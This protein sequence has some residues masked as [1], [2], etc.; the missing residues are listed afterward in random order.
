MVAEAERAAAICAQLERILARPEFEGAERLSNF[1]RFIVTESLAGRGDQ[2]KEYVIGTEVYRKPASYEP[3]TDATVRVEASKLRARLVAYYETEG[4]NAPILIE[5]PKG[6]Y[7]PVFTVRQPEAAGVTPASALGISWKYA[8]IALV[9]LALTAGALFVW[10]KSPTSPQPSAPVPVTAYPGSERHPS[11]S[12]DGSQVAFDWSGPD[13]NRDIYV[14]LVSGGTPLRLTSDPA[15]DE[16]PSWSPDGQ[17]IA[18]VRQGQGAFVVSALGGSERKGIPADEIASSYGVM[19]WTPDSHSLVIVTRESP[20]APSRLRAVSLENGTRTELTS[21]PPGTRGDDA[22]AL[23][24][25]GSNIAFIRWGD[26]TTADVYVVPVTGGEPKRI[27]RHQAIMWGVTWTTDGKSVVFASH[28]GGTVTLWRASVEHAPDEHTERIPGIQ[29]VA[30]FPA[31]SR[32]KGPGGSRLI[33][34]QV[35]ED[36]NIWAMALPDPKDRSA[37]AGKPRQVIAST[38][39]DVTPQFSPDGSR[40]SFASN[41]TGHWEI[42]TCAADGSGLRQLTSIRGPHIG[43]ARWSPNGNLLA[44]NFNSLP[45]RYIWTIHSDGSARRQ[46]MSG[47]FVDARAA[48]SN[49]GR[50][51]FFRSNRSGMEQI[52]RVAAEGGDPAQI[53]RNGGFEPLAAPDGL[54]IYYTQV[55]EPGLW[56]V[57]I[58]GGP[59]V[60][61]LDRVRHGYWTVRRHGVYFFDLDDMPAGGPFPV[62]FWDPAGNK[63]VR[64]A[65]A[66]GPLVRY[67]PS[68]DVSPD[69]R[70]LMWAKND[71]LESDLMMIENFH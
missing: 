25:D 5:V 15:S 28:L 42:Y 22:P 7:V 13:N 38:L 16:K 46:L 17:Q 49:D 24:P 26:W 59:E 39:E 57:P 70:T 11:L 6:A 9:A 44:F 10:E 48:W 63:T 45:Y 50:W 64:L 21:P 61:V 53:T 36:L 32:T 41:R 14:Q 18:F 71:R 3:K 40:I 51:I 60:R 62:M 43:S 34:Q 67:T 65:E 35:L 56:S 52:W 8:S 58:D 68:F 33:Y 2:I 55:N 23:S 4:K 1:L 31:I 37:R 19:C 12:P 29:G 69:G 66:D 47:D 20:S 30:A 27:T 54:H